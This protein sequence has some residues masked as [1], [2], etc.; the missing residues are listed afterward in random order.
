MTKAQLILF[1][2]DSN[3]S[4]TACVSH[5]SRQP[6]SFT[7]FATALSVTQAARLGCLRTFPFPLLVPHLRITSF[8]LPVA[9]LASLTTSGP[10]ETTPSKRVKGILWKEQLR[11]S[12]NPQIPTFSQLPEAHSHVRIERDPAL[13]KWPQVR[14]DICV[15]SCL[16][17][18]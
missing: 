7:P 5:C 4:S 12:C 1:Q 13:Q 16:L 11:R 18:S 15:T 8:L 6:P 17:S 10:L 9:S 2:L 3:E 14:P